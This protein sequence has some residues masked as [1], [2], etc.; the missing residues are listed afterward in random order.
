MESGAEVLESMSAY[1]QGAA[2]IRDAAAGVGLM[3]AGPVPSFISRDTPATILPVVSGEDLSAAAPADPVATLQ[4]LADGV[5]VSTRV[6]TR[7][8]LA[9]GAAETHAAYYAQVNKTTWLVDLDG[10][11]TA[12]PLPDGDLSVQVTFEGQ[13]KVW[14]DGFWVLTE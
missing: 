2:V 5:V 13:G 8:E 11:G 9:A 6:I 1:S 4:L 10:D 12:D 7:G 14:L 3:Y